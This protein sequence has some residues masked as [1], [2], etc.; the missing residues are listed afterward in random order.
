MTK[1]AILDVRVKC[2]ACGKMHMAYIKDIDPDPDGNVEY[3]ANCPETDQTVLI[4]ASWVIFTEP[5]Q[6]DLVS[7]E[8]A[9]TG[10]SPARPAGNDKTDIA[11]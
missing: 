5:G 6:M 7:D 11:D 2:P 10:N 9:K 4:Y 8:R 1:P 3:R